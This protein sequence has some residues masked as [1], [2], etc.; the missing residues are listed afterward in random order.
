MENTYKNPLPKQNATHFERHKSL[1]L[2]AVVVGKFVHHHRVDFLN[3][4]ALAASTTTIFFLL[5]ANRGSAVRT[6]KNA[7]CLQKKSSVEIKSEKR[8]HVCRV[9]N[10]L[11]HLVQK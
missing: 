9:L 10:V 11:I 6:T 4:C 2:A 5:C 7:Q 1:R 8:C 3:K